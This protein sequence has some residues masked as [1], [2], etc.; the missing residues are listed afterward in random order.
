MELPFAVDASTDS[1]RSRSEKS[2]RSNPPTTTLEDSTGTDNDS[3]VTASSDGSFHISVQGHSSDHPEEEWGRKSTGSRVSNVLSHFG[4][5]ERATTTTTTTDA[6]H[7]SNRVSHQAKNDDGDDAE[8]IDFTYVNVQE[9]DADEVDILLAGGDPGMM[10]AQHAVSGNSV[11]SLAPPN[12]LALFLSGRAGD[13]EI[14]LKLVN[15]S[16]E[17]NDAVQRATKAKQE[18]QL[19]Q[20]LDAHSTAARLFYE[21]AI[22]LKD[23]NSA[24]MANSFLLLS[25]T[26]AK[27][28]LALKRV[29]KLRP[30]TLLTKERLRATVRGALDK[31][32]E[33]DISDSMFLGT[34][35]SQ[36][37]ANKKLNDAARK[38]STTASLSEPS[39]DTLNN[40]NNPVDELMQLQRELQNMQLGNSI[41]SLDGRS[42]TRLRNSAIDGSF[43]VVP[44]DLNS[45]LSS[46]MVLSANT[47]PRITRNT[48]PPSNA[49]AR[50]NRV[51]SIIEASSTRP[52]AQVAAPKPAPVPAPPSAPGG[53]ESSWWGTASQ[54]LSTSGHQSQASGSGA[55]P[56]KELLRL[57]D[58]LKTLG[59]ENAA[60]LREV[61]EAE[62]VRAEAKAAKKEMQRF[63]EVYTERFEKLKT[64]LEKFRKNYPDASAQCQN[65]VVNPVANSEYMQ[66]ASTSEQLQRQE[67]LIKK[68]TADLKKE[69]EENRKKDAAISKYE[70]FYREVKARSAQKAAQRHGRPRPQQQQQQPSNVAAA[71]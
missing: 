46:S 37:A 11:E 68:L 61:K 40:N 22:L 31:K 45:Y 54:V 6:A 25:Q 43:M 8:I 28:A 38:L 18:N 62:A 16:E 13:D 10:S 49:R 47:S 3:L 36:S 52:A 5:T 27:S 17:A 39:R 15:L 12:I 59:D 65:G 67:Q 35:D 4:L 14:T 30:N 69:K 20:A 26:E 42:G 60:L 32:A 58:S 1:G 55:A 66:Q 29:I 44:P 23:R 2:T 56:T 9:T 21:A 64:A 51:Q 41:A 34:V 63:R 70:T 71:R 24:C 7:G 50:A 33:A 53:L 48:A 57:M 19:A